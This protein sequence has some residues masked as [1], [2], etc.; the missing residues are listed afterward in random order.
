MTHVNLM[1]DPGTRRGRHGLG[2]LITLIVV[3]SA[4]VGAAEVL[5]PSFEDTYVGLPW[6]RL[7]PLYWG[8]VDHPSF[9]SYCT[10]LWRTNGGQA[11]VLFSRIGQ[12]VSPGDYQSFY[13]YI[14]LT[15]MGAIQ[16]DACLVAYPAGVFEHFEAS[17]LVDGV[18]LWS[19]NVGGVYLD[20]Q[21][22]VAGRAGW[23][24]IEIR[25]TAL[26]SGTFHLAYWTQWD[27]VRLVE[28]PKT[29]PAQVDLEPGT[30]NL[31][32][33]GKWITCYIELPTGYDAN[34]IDGA[35]VTFN[36]LPAVMGKQ[37]WAT[38]PGSSE[39][40]ADYDQ[41]GVTERMVKFERAAVQALVQPQE[42]TVTIKGRLASG[43]PFEGTTILRVRGKEA[44]NE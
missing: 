39:N 43:T 15:G 9:N 38:P 5:N 6:P 14:D 33:K 42:V 8:H 35:T 28:G 3:V 20:Q 30:L 25:N 18:P 44:T 11:A 27:N 17:F 40:V 34:Q 41:D 16:F 13:Q 10:N 26:D 7:L 32:S 19:R 12:P 4:S 23:H 1:P 24:R 22:N 31:A 36:D 2:W 21:V 37:G 29:I